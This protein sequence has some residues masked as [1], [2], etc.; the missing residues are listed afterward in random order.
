[1]PPQ[2]P[3]A[4][5]LPRHLEKLI[6]NW[7][8][9]PTTTTTTTTSASIAPSSYYNR[10]TSQSRDRVSA[11]R[12]A[13]SSPAPHLPVTT[14]SGTNLSPHSH[15]HSQSHSPSPSHYPPSGS[16]SA[17]AA[18][19]AA[20]YTKLDTHAREE[21]LSPGWIGAA[22]NANPGGAPGLGAGALADDGS[23]L[24][25]PSHVVLCHLGTSAIRNGVLA[26]A[27]T[28]RY[29]KKV[30]FGFFFGLSDVVVL[31]C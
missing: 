26:V 21:R 29:R 25:V 3:M 31:G 2:H 1:V 24:P 9:R 22:S 10:D 28:V 18:A 27:D 8:G 5:A 11:L 23:V 17:T 12:N 4:P 6:M 20:L 14:A 15:S 30:S 13:E 16:A 19:T 7:R